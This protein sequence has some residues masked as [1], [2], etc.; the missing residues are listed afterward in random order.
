MCWTSLN[1]KLLTNHLMI[2]LN[3]TNVQLSGI[4][5]DASSG[6]PGNYFF[7]FHPGCESPFISVSQLIKLKGDSFACHS[8]RMN[9]E[10]K[11]SQS[12]QWAKLEKWLKVIFYLFIY[13]LNT[14]QM[15]CLW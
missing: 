12:S 15:L 2:S 5:D 10:H 4:K 6:S 11:K 7:T 9:V 8:V 14:Y 1:L 3:N 13:S